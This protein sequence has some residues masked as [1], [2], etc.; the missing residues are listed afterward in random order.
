MSTAK[1]TSPTEKKEP[2]TLPVK[3]PTATEGSA[4]LPALPQTTSEKPTA[5]AVNDPYKHFLAE[6]KERE[7]AWKTQRAVKKARLDSCK[8][9]TTIE[10]PTI[11]ISD[12]GDESV[13]QVSRLQQQLDAKTDE[14]CR[15]RSQLVKL[16]E[17][18]AETVRTHLESQE[19]LFKVS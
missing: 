3:T 11:E 7:L 19:R 6:Q 12:A 9:S 18:N 5:Q 13:D 16:K 2:A 17:D 4:T 14:C 8:K 1:T 10:E 15:L